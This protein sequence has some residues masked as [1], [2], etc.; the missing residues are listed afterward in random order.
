MLSTKEFYEID[1]TQG[2]IVSKQ[3]GSRTFVLALEPW[4]ALVQ[5]LHDT[6]GSGAQTILYDIGKSYGNSVIEEEKGKK[7]GDE[8]ELRIAFL[9]RR[10]TIAGWGKVEISHPSND[11][12]QVKIQKCVFCDGIRDPE[13]KSVP[14]FFV[15]GVISGFA[16]ALIG[17]NVVAEEHCGTDYCEFS[18]RIIDHYLD[19]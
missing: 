7:S 18:V 19:F 15:R 14:C 3:H 8:E 4:T 9:A 12:Y 6:F 2:I 13:V 11:L 16:E 17:K 1:E 10:A 5:K